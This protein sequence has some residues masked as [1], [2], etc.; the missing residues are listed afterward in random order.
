[1]NG[2]LASARGGGVGV[3]VLGDSFPPQPATA[4]VATRPAQITASLK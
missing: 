2:R 3:V 4:T 1:M